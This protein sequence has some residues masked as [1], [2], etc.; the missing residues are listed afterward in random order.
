[1][2]YTRV[3]TAVALLAALAACTTAKD[4]PSFNPTPR[5]TRPGQV[6]IIAGAPDNYRPPRDGEY[7]VK[8]GAQSDGGLAVDPATGLVYFRAL[9]NDASV[10]VRI[11][12]D[13]RVSTFR[14]K[15]RGG[16]LA[17]VSGQLWIMSSA[18]GLQLSK[19]ALSTLQE[20]DVL[21]TE[22][23]R[24]IRILDEAGRPVSSSEQR[25]LD[26]QWTDSRF[27]MRGDGRP[28]IVSGAGDLFE[29]QAANEVRIWRPSGF[30]E[31]RRKAMG[32]GK[33]RPL[34]LVANGRSGAIVL[35]ASGL[36]RIDTG[37]AASGTAFP[38]LPRGIPAWSAATP[39]A[40]GSVLLLGGT[41]AFERKPRPALLRPD[42]RLV[43]LSLGGPQWC[44]QFDGSMAI[45]AS[46]EPGGL[47]VTP[48]GD[49]LVMDKNC[50]RI[51][52][53]R[54]PADI[55]GVPRRG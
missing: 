11:E 30:E 18:K 41:T 21:T 15:N 23:D 45:V 36:V 12:R 3:T 25:K 34:A 42:G 53:F 19:M 55:G 6:V 20:T 9:A 51:Y 46:A 24:P 7:A 29:V 40:D 49:H 37:G 8:A 17:V 4:T 35:A 44:G 5:P 26:G 32:S 28:I 10:V 13:G 27:A 16:Q 39:L 1:M 54:L 52:S 14:V 50:G 38:G 48:G 2:R 33:Q 47:A 31:A 43:A 22:N